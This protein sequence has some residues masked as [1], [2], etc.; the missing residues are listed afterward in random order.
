MRLKKEVYKSTTKKIYCSN[1][2]K[3]ITGY[4]YSNRRC[5]NC[6]HQYISKLVKSL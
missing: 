6:I 2:G 4:L 5:L 3:L 1:C